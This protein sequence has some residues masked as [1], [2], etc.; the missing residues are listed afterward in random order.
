MDPE[1]WRKVE[2]VFHEAR[3]ADDGRRSEVLAAACA[4]DEALRREAESLLLRLN[5]VPSPA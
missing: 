2:S 3:E 4:G 5:R 1:R